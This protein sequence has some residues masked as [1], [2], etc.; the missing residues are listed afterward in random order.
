MKLCIDLNVI[1]T[2][3][4]RYRQRLEELLENDDGGSRRFQPGMVKVLPLVRNSL[5]GVGLC[6]AD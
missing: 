4:A 6:A 1:V 2:A 3:F 5:L